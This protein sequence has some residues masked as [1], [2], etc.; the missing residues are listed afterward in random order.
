MRRDSAPSGQSPSL[1]QN[2]WGL[3]WEHKRKTL[4]LRRVPPGFLSDWWTELSQENTQWRYSILLLQVY[5]VI[6]P[7]TKVEDSHVKPHRRETLS[8]SPVSPGFLPVCSPKGKKSLGWRPKPSAGARSKAYLV[9]PRSGLY[10]LVKLKVQKT[11]LIAMFGVGKLAK[12]CG[13]KL[14]KY[15]QVWQKFSLFLTMY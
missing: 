10:L 11:S 14:L 9:S 2:T 3:T 5:N 8:L 15:K 4:F 7:V 13:I 6:L 1:D 12:H